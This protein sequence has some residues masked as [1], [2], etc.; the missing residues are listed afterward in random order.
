MGAIFKQKSKNKKGR[1]KCI[2]WCLDFEWGLK[3]KSHLLSHL[4]VCLFSQKKW[5]EQC[6]KK[7][8]RSTKTICCSSFLLSHFI[9]RRARYSGFFFRNKVF[10]KAFLWDHSSQSFLQLH[11]EQ[12]ISVLTF[13]ISGLFKIIQTLHILASYVN[14]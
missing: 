8:F 9:R 13:W 2:L 7:Y 10:K 1:K 14:L 11:F 5:G 4:R 12:N 3:Q 6:S